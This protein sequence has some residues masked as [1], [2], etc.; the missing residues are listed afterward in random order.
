VKPEK[1]VGKD[2]TKKLRPENNCEKEKKL[3]KSR[4]KAKCY[5]GKIL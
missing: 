1:K 2:N 5:K 4:E 3:K